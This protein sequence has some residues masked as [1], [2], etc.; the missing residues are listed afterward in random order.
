MFHSGGLSSELNTLTSFVCKYRG[1]ILTYDISDISFTELPT[2]KF[3]PATIYY[4]LLAPR[5]LANDINKILYLD[6]DLVVR[7]SLRGL[8]EIDLDGYAL[9]AVEDAKWDP[10]KEAFISVFSME[11]APD[12]KYFNSGVMLINLSYWRLNAVSERAIAF[13]KNHQER[14]NFW[15]QDALNAVL[16]GRWIILPAVWNAHHQ[17]VAGV[18]RVAD[19]AIVHYCG[20][21]KPWHWRWHEILHPY[22]YEY[23]RY[24]KRTPWRRYKP[25]GRPGWPGRM[26]Q[27]VK[28]LLPLKVRQQL[29]FRIARTGP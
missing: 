28:R 13:V 29:R 19:P 6:S 20:D 25:E 11:L 7:R 2:N 9:A 18:S 4:R 8:W 14:L 5:I 3:F 22:K 16:N 15:D 17:Q 26:K 12:T 27:V 1:N 24:R 10:T 21:I 23:H